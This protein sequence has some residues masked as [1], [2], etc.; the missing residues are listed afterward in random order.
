MLTKTR[1]E[2]SIALAARTGYGL[3]VGWASWAL[4]ILALSQDDPLAADTAL[5]LRRS[6]PA[7]LTPSEQRV[8]DLAAAGRTNREV[9]AQLFMSPKTVE[10]NLARIYRKLG[11]RSRAELGAQLGTTRLI[12]PPPLQ[13]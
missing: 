8:A 7:E 13:T 6:A 9:A 10:A 2:E 3:A 1:A 5:G 12:G 4:A 11:V